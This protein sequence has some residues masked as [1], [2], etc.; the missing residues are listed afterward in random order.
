MGHQRV[1]RFELI[2]GV[3]AERALAVCGL[4]GP[5]VVAVWGANGSAVVGVCGL[6]GPA[7]LAVWGAIG[8]A[9]VVRAGASCCCPLN[10][11]GT[12]HLWLGCCVLG[13]HG[14]TYFC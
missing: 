7:V 14:L 11:A 10:R 12:L 8:P 9:A 5:A 6:N 13:A 4:N 2:F 1:Q 3:Q